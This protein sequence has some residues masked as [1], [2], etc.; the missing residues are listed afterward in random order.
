MNG[1][2][3]ISWVSAKS[4]SSWPRRIAMALLRRARDIG[5]GDTRSQSRLTS[6]ITSATPSASSA[7]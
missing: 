3:L 6:R 5:I 4:S 7:R 2:T 1:V